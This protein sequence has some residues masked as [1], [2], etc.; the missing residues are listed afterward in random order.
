MLHMPLCISIYVDVYV[1]VDV[2]MY[3]CVYIY[4]YILQVQYAQVYIG[5]C[6]VL[7][8]TPYDDFELKLRAVP[9]K[10][11]SAPR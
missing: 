7:F 10:V 1:D 9:F 11:T 5:A 4:I 3:V 2:C 8:Y 6:H